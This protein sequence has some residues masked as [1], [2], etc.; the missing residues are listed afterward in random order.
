MEPCKC[1]TQQVVMF[2]CLRQDCPDRAGQPLYCAVC[3]KTRHDHRSVLI[4]NELVNMQQKWAALKEKIHE[5]K[6]KIEPTYRRL[7]PLIAYVE[8]EMQ[9]NKELAKI[10]WIQNT[11]NL[12]EDF[13]RDFTKYTNKDL[14][15]HVQKA[16]ILELYNS[17]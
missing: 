16:S 11:F 10:T 12:F 15:Q 7:L 9:K 3:A 13:F 5:F 17:I 2:V 1:G 4:A 6:N 8:S 14:A